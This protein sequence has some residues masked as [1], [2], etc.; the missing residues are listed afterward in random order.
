MRVAKTTDE[1]FNQLAM[2]T[3][4][5]ASEL[6]GELV[7]T[8]LETMA[9]VLMPAITAFRTKNPN[10]IIRYITNGR[11]IK[12][13]YGEAHIAVR[14]GPKPT[15]LDNVVQPFMASEMGLYASQDYIDRKGD[16]PD[17]SKHDYIGP[18]DKNVGAPFSNGFK[19]TSQ[20]SKLF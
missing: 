11:V 12:L 5:N 7:I 16:I 1:Q 14:A 6:S 3:K 20:Q 18:H 10:V 19:K 15:D 9:S 17:L 2:R 8:S 4:G 13:E